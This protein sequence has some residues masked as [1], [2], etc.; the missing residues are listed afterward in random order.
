MYTDP[1]FILIADFGSRLNLILSATLVAIVNS[2][3]DVN[4]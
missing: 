3:Q 2:G 1:L 4:K